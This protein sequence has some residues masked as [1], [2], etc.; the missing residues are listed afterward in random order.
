MD[1]VRFI[2]LPAIGMLLTGILWANL[3]T[4]ALIGGLVWAAIGFVYLLVLTRGFRR[5]VAA[6]D[7]NQPVTGFTKAVSRD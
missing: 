2:V 7:E 5:K 3:H 4:D 6:F 1:I